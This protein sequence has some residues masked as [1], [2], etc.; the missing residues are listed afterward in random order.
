M[1][2]VVVET[3]FDTCVVSILSF[4]C[5]Q[6]HYSLQ[7]IDMLHVLSNVFEILASVLI[8]FCS[9]VCYNYLPWKYRFSASEYIQGITN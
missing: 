3:N 6:L 7:H 2:L 8:R 4:V 5:F 1:P 9:S